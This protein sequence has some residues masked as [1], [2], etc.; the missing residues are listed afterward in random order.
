MTL[1]AEDRLDILEVVT[2]ADNCATTRD[3]DAYVGL[4]TEDATMTGAMGAA[5]G[6]D[7]LRRAVSTVWAGEPA[8]TLHVT[9]NPTIDD[10]DEEPSVTSIML[11]VIGDQAPRLLGWASVRQV[12]RRTAEGWKIASRAILTLGGTAPP[13]PS[14]DEPR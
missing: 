6:R 13:Q 14:V 2:L 1:T 9:L 3:V 8:T 4:F 7:A 5:T 11:M 12:V 10:S